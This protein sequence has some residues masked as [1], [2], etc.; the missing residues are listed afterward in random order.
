MNTRLLSTTILA[1]FLGTL[2][3][4]FSAETSHQNGSN[5][6]QASKPYPLDTCVVSGESLKDGFISHTYK[7]QELRFC[8]KGCK[9][10]FA[11]DPETYL[12][13]LKKAEMKARSSDA[14]PLDTCVVS[15]MKLGSMGDPYVHKVGD[16]EVRFC[17]KGC[18]P[19][20]EKDQ[21][22]Y[23]KKLEAAK[24]SQEKGREK[25]D[26]HQNHHH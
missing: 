9:K 4:G 3:V 26:G 12:R 11:K 5:V 15:G 20:F 19:K 24:P 23:L 22:K 21:A 16:K 6:E 1:L 13:K 17:C 18:L 14:Y 7:G 25:Q 10:D 8:C 2:S